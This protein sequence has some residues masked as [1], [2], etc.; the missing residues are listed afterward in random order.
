MLCHCWI[1][2]PQY[3]DGEQLFIELFLWSYAPELE[4]NLQDPP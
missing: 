4:L 1:D 3:C 2:L